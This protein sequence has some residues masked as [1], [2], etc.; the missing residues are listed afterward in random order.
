MKWLVAGLATLILAGCQM[1]G[2]VERNVA[3]PADE[4]AALEKTGTS[5]IEGQLFMRTRGGD[6]KYG[7]GSEIAVAPV[8]SYSRETTRIIREGKTPTL[9]DSRVS[10]F[11]HKTQADGEGRF[12]VT[13][14]P[15]GDFYVVGGVWWE[16]GSP[17]MP[18]Q[19]GV[20]IKQVHLDEGETQEVMLTQ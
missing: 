20:V 10:A 13:G 14:L 6:V 2:P 18:R 16:T 15:A 8:T 9:A 19:G 4:Y 12:K 1:A 17:Y 3:Y 5:A 7:A 11:T